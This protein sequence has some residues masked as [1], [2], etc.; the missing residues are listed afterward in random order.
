MDGFLYPDLS[1]HQNLDG[2][3]YVLFPFAVNLTT[4]VKYLLFCPCRFPIRAFIRSKLRPK[5]L[6]RN[7]KCPWGPSSPDPVSP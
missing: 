6:P 1:L 7:R 4:G 3:S 2:G 5:P